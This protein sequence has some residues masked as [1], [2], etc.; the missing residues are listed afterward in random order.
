MTLDLDT[1]RDAAFVRQVLLLLADS[2]CA[3][4]SEQSLRDLA[5][6]GTDECLAKLWKL[7]R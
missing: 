3:G 2:D 6:D 4:W 7:M 5:K 1:A